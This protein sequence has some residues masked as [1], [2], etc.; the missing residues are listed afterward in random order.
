MILLF[1]ITVSFIVS[2]LLTGFL[3]KYA[4]KHSLIDIPNNR[5]SHSLPTPRGGGVA[6]VFAY[7][8]AMFLLFL[9][10]F[11]S[12]REGVLFWGSGIIV[13][14]VGFWD[15]HGHVLP[16]WRL[17]FHFLA[18]AW[19]LYWIG[20]FPEIILWDEYLDLGWLGNLLAIIFLVW[21]LNLYNFMDGIDAIASIEAI[22]VCFSVIFLYIIFIPDSSHWMMLVVLMS[23]VAGF[24]YWNYP[25]AKIFMGD[26][27]SGFV[28]LTLGLLS[29]LSATLRFDFFWAWLILL[30][31]FIVDATVTLFFRVYSGK[32]IHEAHRSHAYQ[33]ASR[34]FGTHKLVSLVIGFINL[35]W[36]FPV[37]ICVMAEVVDGLVGLC[38]AYIP[39]IATVYYFNAGNCRKQL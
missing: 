4:I 11:I 22:T 36:L 33:F 24:L 29:I 7:T 17:F 32:K 19:G 5:S 18:A 13:A 1:I 14:I 2:I 38:I 20:G 21:L 15:D 12:L 26:A 6:I 8:F 34:K 28:G 37:A 35:F 10:D 23:S 27:G 16:A 9:N 30:G 3:R 25:P 39:L 31:A